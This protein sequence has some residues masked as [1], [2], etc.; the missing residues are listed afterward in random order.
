VF[1]HSP[2]SWPELYL[3]KVIKHTLGNG[4]H[5]NRSGGMRRTQNPRTGRWESCLEIEPE[6][7]E[8]K[9]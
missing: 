5:V 3:L 1:E 8:G 6:V 9:F 7:T 4:T 2:D